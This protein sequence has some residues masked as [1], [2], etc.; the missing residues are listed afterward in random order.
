MAPAA[1][2]NMTLPVNDEASANAQQEYSG[3]SLSVYVHL[4][5]FL[6][7]TYVNSRGVL[8]CTYTLSSAHT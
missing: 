1:T 6:T 7:S 5:F 3:N 8:S 2:T 4:F